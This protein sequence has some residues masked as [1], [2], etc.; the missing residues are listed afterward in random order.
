MN[1]C[2][3]FLGTAG[4]IPTLKRNL[5]AIAIRRGEELFLFDC[6]EGTQRQMIQ[7]KVGFHRKTKIFI[8]HLHGDHILGLPGLIQTTSLL[9]RRKKIEIYGPQ[10]IKAF[11]DAIKENVRFT[12]IFPIEVFEIKSPG[13]ICEDNGYE[14]STVWVNHSIPSLAYVFTEKH[15]PG[16][17]YPERA[18][19]LG[20]P[21][22]TMW[23]K[24]QHGNNVTLSSGV[25]VKSEEVVGPPRPGRKIA[26]SG[27]TRPS[28]DFIKLAEGADL[29]IHEATFDDELQ[30]RAFKD[31]H[32]TPCQ[33][34]KVAMKAKTKQ[35][36]LTHISARYKDSSILCEQAMN[37]FPNVCIAEDFMRIDVPLT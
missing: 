24:L 37:L 13:I 10:G 18:S 2:V 32:S 17:F 33:A 12:L 27:D 8:T 19:S 1:L 21:E 22:G 29:L 26:Y 3:I 34:A 9:N 6:G 36:A 16:K 30:E 31:G 11:I 15:R 23:S 7:A 14:V 28:E 5:P 20:V 25:I 35:L 4:S